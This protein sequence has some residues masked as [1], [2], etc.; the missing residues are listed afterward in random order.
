MNCVE[1]RERE[2]CMGRTWV[3][4]WRSPEGVVFWEVVVTFW[5]GNHV[6]WGKLG[7]GCSVLE[8][9]GVLGLRQ[10]G[11]GG[12]LVSSWNQAWWVYWA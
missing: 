6:E 7:G 8:A 4:A 2:S 5:D 1:N 11:R 9:G 10:H 3:S 12:R